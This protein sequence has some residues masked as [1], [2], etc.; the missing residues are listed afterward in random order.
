MHLYGLIIGIALIIGFQY[1]S[2]HQKNLSEKQQ[3]IFFWGITIFSIIGARAYHV[4]DQW[5]YYSQHLS[6]IPATWNGGLGIFGGII[7]ALIFIF[8]FSKF[9]KLFFLNILD[10]IS[11]IMPLCQCVGRFGN[12]V[13]HENPIWWPEAILDFLLFLIILKFPKKPTAKYLI[14]YGIIR[15]ITEF[16]RQDTWV[17][18]QIKIGQGISLLFLII[19]IALFYN[20]YNKIKK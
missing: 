9:Y 11:P 6:Q 3:N 10:S 7:G 18:N 2:K 15:F 19:G 13:N 20:N 5:A 1:F 12:Y 14:G 4:I 17:V 16:W 8:L